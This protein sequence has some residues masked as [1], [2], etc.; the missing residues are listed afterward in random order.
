MK[1]NYY[2]KYIIFPF[3]AFIFSNASA[4]IP[5]SLQNNNSNN[6]WS[7]VTKP[8]KFTLAD[9]ISVKYDFWD[10]RDFSFR[11]EKCS[12]PEI[13]EVLEINYGP[14]PDVNNAIRYR[15]I[16]NGFIYAGDI[17][18]AISGFLI[19][20]YSLVKNYNNPNTNTYPPPD[21]Q[22]EQMENVRNQFILDGSILLVFGIPALIFDAKSQNSRQPIIEWH[23]HNLKFKR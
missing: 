13:G 12:L 18:M 3:I 1:Y 9:T 4:Q 19:L 22:A 10:R 20:Y 11:N 17:G 7:K 5:D 15:K 14:L 21:Y 6:Y 2:S 8:M 23:N 16:S